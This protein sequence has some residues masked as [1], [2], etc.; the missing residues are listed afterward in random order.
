MQH[1]HGNS[2]L[3]IIAYYRHTL[4][5]DE[6]IGCRLWWLILCIFHSAYNFLERWIWRQQQW[7]TLEWDETKSDVIVP[8]IEF[9]FNNNKS[10][11]SLPMRWVTQKK[12]VSPPKAKIISHNLH[13]ADARELPSVCQPSNIDICPQK[14]VRR[15]IMDSPPNDVK[16]NIICCEN[17]WAWWLMAIIEVFKRGNGPAIVVIWIRLTARLHAF[18]FQVSMMKNY[19]WTYEL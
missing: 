4:P 14:H 9:I 19:F 8:M 10:Y 13:I 2:L 7:M 11:L 5:D 18:I 17:W 6:V 3:M 15:P 12:Y 16:V 1:G